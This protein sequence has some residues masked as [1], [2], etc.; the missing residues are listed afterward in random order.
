MHAW[1]SVDQVPELCA[2]NGPR[3]LMVHK[4]QQQ[5]LYGWLPGRVCTYAGHCLWAAQTYRQPAAV[6][7]AVLMVTIA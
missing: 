7:V 5:A 3:L 4:A 1:P 6:V 2:R